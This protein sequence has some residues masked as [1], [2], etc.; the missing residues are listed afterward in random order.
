MTQYFEDS[1]NFLN[2]LVRNSVKWNYFEFNCEHNSILLLINLQIQMFRNFSKIFEKC[3]QNNWIWYA[4]DLIK[5]FFKMIQLVKISSEKDYFIC[6]WIWL[7][8]YPISLDSCFWVTPVHYLIDVV[9]SQILG[10][11]LD[12]WV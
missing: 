6:T 5:M 12:C 8:A 10:R 4:L 11:R 2:F 3:F 1:N 9:N 7:P